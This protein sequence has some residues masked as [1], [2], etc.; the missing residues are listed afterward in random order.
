[1]IEVGSEGDFRNDATLAALKVED[2]TVGSTLWYISSSYRP[3]K[4]AIVSF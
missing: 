4:L 1:M 2:S 3:P